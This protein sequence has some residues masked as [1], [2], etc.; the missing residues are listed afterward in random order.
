LSLEITEEVN[1]FKQNKSPNITLAESLNNEII[2]NDL[3]YSNLVAVNRILLQTIGRDIDTLTSGQRDSLLYIANQ[4]PLDGG[5]SVYMARSLYNLYGP[6]DINDDSICQ[7]VL[8][9]IITNTQQLDKLEVSYFPV[10]SKEALKFQFPEGRY[11]EVEISLIDVPTGKTIKIYNL[12]DIIGGEINLRIHDITTGMYI[13][14][15]KT[16]GET[17]S[18][19]KIVITK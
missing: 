2:A 16:K 9:I 4:C 13:F 7:P 11:P 5:K 15:L 8:P 10:P 17:V 19:G 18:T 12:G 1:Q 14:T 3:L 6:L